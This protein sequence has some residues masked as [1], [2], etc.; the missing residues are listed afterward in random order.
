MHNIKM[1]L[2]PQNPENAFKVIESLKD[3]GQKAY[4]VRSGD[5]EAI[6]ICHPQQMWYSDKNEIISPNQLKEKYYRII[7]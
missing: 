3:P 1:R 2:L 5:F 7:A 4:L 6:R